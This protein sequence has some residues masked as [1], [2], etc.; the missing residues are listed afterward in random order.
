MRILYKFLLLIFTPVLFFVFPKSF[1]SRIWLRKKLKQSYWLHCASLG[2]INALISFIETLKK[3]TSLPLVLSVWTKTGYERALKIADITVIY[4][5]LD[6][7][8][9]MRSFLKKIN[10]KKIFIMET[11]LWANFLFEAQKKGIKTYLINARLS[12]NAFL[13]Y[14]KYAP[15]F[16]IKAL[17]SITHIYAQSTQDEQRF[18]ALKINQKNISITGNLKFDIELNRKTKNQIEIKKQYDWQDRKVFLAASVREGEEVLILEC[19]TKLKEKYPNS[20]L[21]IAPRHKN[22]FKVVE[23]LLEQQ[24]FIFSKRTQ[25]SVKKEDEVFLLDT[26]GELILFYDFA[27]VIFVGGSL[28]NY[29]GHNLIEAAIFNAATIVGPFMQN[30]KDVVRLFK[31]KEAVVEVENVESLVQKVNELFLNE[32]LRMQQVKNA[33]QLIEEN[34]GQIKKIMSTI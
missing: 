30:S 7:S 8:W 3:Q 19:F 29:G 32:N 4:F 2:E 18:L 23:Q 33:H 11:E 9:I 6:F 21:I 10:P 15:T 1:F 20:L 31:E 26:F 28:K 17:Q 14:H 22:Q 24:Q 25:K 16:F 5:P 27:Q 34:K 12:E 13:N